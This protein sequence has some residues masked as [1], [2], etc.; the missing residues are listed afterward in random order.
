M[1]ILFN[2]KGNPIKPGVIRS[3]ISN[4]GNS[5]NETVRE[6]I[7][8]SRNGVDR[9]IFFQNVAKLMPNFKMTRQGPFKG[10]YYSD[11]IVKD[12]KG[13]IKACWGGIGDS[14][15]KLRDFLDEERAESRE[16]VLVEISLSAQ[17]EVATQ[18]WKMF[19]KLVSL[20]M[21]KNTLGLVAASKVLFSVFPEVALPI[22][23]A[24]W[25]NVFKTID[26]ADIIML[27]ASEITEWER[28]VKIHLE[29]CDPY[30]NFTL[31]A[32]YNVMAMEAKP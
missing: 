23:N 14:A 10:I 20:C 29:S 12:P 8:N 15:V 3:S 1:K 28:M 19:K 7:V 22:D 18:L 26:Y 13:Q 11:G 24:Q 5:Y 32:V 25:R 30:N 4:F 31:P 9:K 2:R 21:G 6:V 17:K 16:R 27:M